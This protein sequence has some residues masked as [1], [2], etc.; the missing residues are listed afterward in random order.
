MKRHRLAFL[1]RG[2]EHIH[3]WDATCVCGWQSRHHRRK[4]DAVESYRDHLKAVRRK[5]L[6]RLIPAPLT[7]KDRLPEEL[8]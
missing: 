3:R 1:D 8:Q 4:V 5:K 6:D 7:P 2:L